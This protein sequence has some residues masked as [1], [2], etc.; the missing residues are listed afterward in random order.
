[1]NNNQKNTD[2]LLDLLEKEQI[3]EALDYI[4][5]LPE[6]EKKYW[7]VQ[8]IAGVISCYCGM[9][10]EAV[11]IFK[12]TLKINPDA[13]NIY[14]NLA[15][16]YLNM[17]K[18]QHADIML[19]CYEYITNETSGND[20][21][22][23]LISDNKSNELNSVLMIAYY[24]PPLAG[25]GVFRSVKFAKY[26]PEFGWKPTVIAADKAPAGW[27]YTDTS[28]INE[29]PDN[30]DI[31]RIAD[32]VSTSSSFSVNTEQINTII[33]YLKNVLQHDKIAMEIFMPLLN[34][35]EGLKY[36]LTFPCPSLIWSLDVISH[37]EN[38]M[39]INK[40]N[41]VYTTSGPFSSHLIGFY[42]KK[43]YNISWIADYRDPWTSNPYSSYDF[44]KPEHKLFYRLE[45]ILLHQADCN[46]TIVNSLIDDYIQ[47]FQLPLNQ[48]ECITNGYDE[49][50]FKKLKY[51]TDKTKKFTINYSGLMYLQ[52]HNIAPVFEAISQLINEN[53]ID[54]NNIFFR[55]VGK[56]NEEASKKIAETYGLSS[57]FEQTGYVSH[58]QALQSN[59]DS[60]LLLILVGDEDKFKYFYP[61]KIFEYLRSGKP[62]LAIASKQSGVNKILSETGHGETFLSTQTNKIKNKILSEYKKWLNKDKN[63]YSCSPI[64]KI[65]E[66][67]YLT[68]KLADILYTV[69]ENPSKFNEIENQVYDDA[70]LKGGPQG[71]YHKHYT[72]SF[73]YPSWKYAL[74][75][76]LF[77]ERNIDILEIGCGPGQFASLLFDNGFMNYHGFD[78]APEGIKLAHKN[79]PDKKERFFVADAFISPEVIA[80]HD[81]IICFEV[82]EHIQNDLELLER[83][84]KGTKL[85]ISVPNFDDPYH[86]RYFSSEKEV[87]ERYK[88]TIDI[89]DIGKS[90]L[91]NV[92]CLY[93]II[94]KKL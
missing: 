17:N 89:Y 12:N 5:S 55:I 27:N 60:D 43:K 67:K 11:S 39:D 40:F 64:I 62:I 88:N 72:Q 80:K 73:Y 48:I 37:I 21:M 49:D 38:N 52:Q 24:F 77:L 69:Y 44:T 18:Y 81:L 82:L 56:G 10:K 13:S 86:V 83:I 32:K 85:L 58:E 36:L 7:E 3:S 71:S 42:F 6:S 84:Q 87:Y 19:K 57:I 91:S 25:S 31:I 14:Y 46:I 50:D 34:S 22:H 26:L 28:L 33:N 59:I 29:I 74:R 68:M 54:I 8:N 79:N 30:M 51:S 4:E 16:A 76:I 41:V 94:G 20:E 70:Y 47:K 65:Y 63:E 61:G 66:R 78:Y 92:N 9:F 45:N 35:N 1:M 23:S 2:I 15:H 93:Y 53:E 75:Y 90:Y